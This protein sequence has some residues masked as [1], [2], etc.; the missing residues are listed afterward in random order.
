VLV[1]RGLSGEESGVNSR[2]IVEGGYA[3]S[4]SEFWGRK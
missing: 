4:P 1:A 2:Q 3:M